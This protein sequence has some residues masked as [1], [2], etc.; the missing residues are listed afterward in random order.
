[1]WSSQ[2]TDAEKAFD[3]IWQNSTSIYDKIPQQSGY[4]GNVQKYFNIVKATYDK[5]T[6]YSVVKTRNLFL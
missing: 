2:Y 1:M 4:R 6:S 3:S 5:P